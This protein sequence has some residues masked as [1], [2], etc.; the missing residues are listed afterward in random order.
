MHRLIGIG[1]RQSLPGSEP[2]PDEQ[3]L[4][5]D[6][7][8]IRLQPDPQ[9]EA[10]VMTEFLD[11]AWQ[12]RAAGA[13]R[14]RVNAALALD[15]PR[16]TRCRLAFQPGAEVILFPQRIRLRANDPYAASGVPAL[17]PMPPA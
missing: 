17:R 9:G 4:L 16:G 13:L 12:Y 7:A 3:L 10:T 1:G 8:L 2:G 6:P 15:V 11:R 14:L 5:V